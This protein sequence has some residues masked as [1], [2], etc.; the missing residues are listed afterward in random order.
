MVM[1]QTEIIKVLGLPQP[2]V[3]RII[4][5]VIKSLKEKLSQLR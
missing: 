2:K 4:A 5:L 3:S 1:S